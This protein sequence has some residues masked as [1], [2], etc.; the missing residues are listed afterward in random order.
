MLQGVGFDILNILC[1]VY[2]MVTLLYKVNTL[3]RD[4]M[5]CDKNPKM[6]PTNLFFR[7][8]FQ[9]SRRLYF[10]LIFSFLCSLT[11]Y[12]NILDL[13]NGSCRFDPP[14]ISWNAFTLVFMLKLTASIFIFIVSGEKPEDIKHKWC[15]KEVSTA[16]Q[17][18]RKVSHHGDQ[19]TWGHLFLPV[20]P[21]EDHSI[22]H[23]KYNCSWFELCLF[24]EV[25]AI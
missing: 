5:K 11:K 4:R 18:E 15:S 19:G 2:L 20:F 7:S 16:T 6:F 8:L 12:Q 9:F 14:C 1:M 21:Q 13:Q 22:N 10:K 23:N 25:P 17:V 24:Y 3:I